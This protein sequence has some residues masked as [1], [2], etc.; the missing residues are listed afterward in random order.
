M[1]K[2]FPKK[3]KMGLT[4]EE[5]MNIAGGYSYYNV[6]VSSFPKMNPGQL[7]GMLYGVGIRR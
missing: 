5:L 6:P 7:G 1:E 4:D 3:V 2:M